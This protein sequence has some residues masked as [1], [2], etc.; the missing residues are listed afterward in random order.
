MLDCARSGGKTAE[1][2]SGYGDQNVSPGPQTYPGKTRYKLLVIQMK[3]VLLP[4]VPALGKQEDCYKSEA[5][6]GYIVRQSL[7]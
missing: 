3:I 7:S 2:K 5:S 6:P 1:K 4:G